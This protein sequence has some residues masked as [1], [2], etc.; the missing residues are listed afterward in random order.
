MLSRDITGSSIKA[1]PSTPPFRYHTRLPPLSSVK[2]HCIEHPYEQLDENEEP[3]RFGSPQIDEL[4]L[5]PELGPGPGPGPETPRCT[6]KRLSD[7][8]MFFKGSK[9][10][11]EDKDNNKDNNKNK[12]NKEKEKG[13]RRGVVSVGLGIDFYEEELNSRCSSP[14]KNP[15]PAPVPP[16]FV[17]R[18]GVGMGGYG[19]GVGGNMGEDGDGYGEE[20][21]E[22]RVPDYVF[23]RRGSATSQCTTVSFL[24]SFLFM[25]RFMGC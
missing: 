12:E 21:E 20:E 4:E 23:E 14:Y 9:C 19:M 16:A 10:K 24:S 1:A 13:E 2:G 3:F 11:S 15:R 7:E 6:Y 17:S 22:L 5:E 18:F 8:E 25:A